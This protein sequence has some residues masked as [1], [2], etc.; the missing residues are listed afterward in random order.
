MRSLHLTYICIEMEIGMSYGLQ[1]GIVCLLVLLGC[2]KVT[3]QG[4]VSRRYIR[5]TVDSVL[6]NAELFVV[7]AIVLALIFPL[8]GI[9]WDGILMAALTAIGTVCFQSF[10]SMALKTGPVSLTVLIGNFALFFATL[11]SVI[12]YRES[13]YLT[14]L[15]G[16]AF[17]VLSMFLGVKRSED[18]RGVSGK[19]LFFTLLMTFSNAASTIVMKIFTM[20]MSPRIE[21]SGNTFLVIAY[22]IAALLAFSIVFILTQK[23]SNQRLSFGVFTPGVLLFALLIGVVLGMYQ[24]VN[25]IGLEKVDSGF[26]FPTYSGMQSLG[27]TLIGIFL[28]KDKLTLRQKLGIVCGIVCVVLMNLR[29]MK[30]F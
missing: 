17:L 15:I 5:N 4:Q 29:F 9:G 23:K 28:F 27:M 18:E 1:F 22:G 8:G 20:E 24:R 21:N 30:L 19:W 12:A 6:F 11:Y 7:I 13:V 25:M 3:L 10:Y 2:T 26:L 14:Q 16:I